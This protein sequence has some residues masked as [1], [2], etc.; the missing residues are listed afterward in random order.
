MLKEYLKIVIKVS[1]VL[2]IYYFFAMFFDDIY[3]FIGVG[4]LTVV[5]IMLFSVMK[6]NEPEYELEDLCN[7]SKYLLEIQK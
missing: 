1:I 3:I 7:P 2:G 6:S 5:V 4:V